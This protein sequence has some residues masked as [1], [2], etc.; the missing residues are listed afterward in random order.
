MP[1][2]QFDQQLFFKALQQQLPALKSQAHFTAFQAAFEA[3]RGVMNAIFEG[4]PI[5]EGQCMDAL[6]KAFDVSKKMTEMTNKLADVPEAATSKA[7]EEFK[8]PPAEFSEYDDA[9]ALMTELAHIEKL[10]PLNEWYQTNRARID[11]VRSPSV[12][13]PLLDAIRERK[14]FFEKNEQDKKG[15]TP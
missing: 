6:N 15:K 13:N 3:F 12:R 10:G 14:F 1:E 11:R 8:Q 2:P 7:A 5:T 4:N 9:R